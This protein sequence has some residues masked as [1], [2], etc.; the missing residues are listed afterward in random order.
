MIG[1]GDV[2]EVKSGPG[3]YKAE[4]ASLVAVAGR[5]PEKARDWV[6]RHNGARVCDTPEALLADP[7]IDIV[8]IATPPSTHK[9]YTLMAAKAG[10][11]VCVEKPMALDEGECRAMIAACAAA[12]VR[13]Y[14]A[15]YRRSMPRFI[16]V[17]EWIE[18]GAIGEV[19]TVR[20]VQ[21]QPAA[22][23]DKEPGR[24]PWRVRG[25]IA[26]GGKF[27]DMG[28]HELDFFDFLFGPIEEAHGLAANF[29]G[30]YDVEDTVNAVWR[31]K[32]GVQGSG[33]WCYVC[34]QEEDRTVITGSRGRIEFEF[35]SDKPLVLTNEHG[36]RTVSIPNP[37][38][39][40]QPFFQSITDELL[41]RGTCPG[42][43]EAAA[44]TSR[45]AGGLLS[46]YYAARA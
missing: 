28:V 34:G 36:V 30:L 27:V 20:V 12:G 8:Y 10:K 1:H 43:A 3:L 26:G 22:G 33:S 46:G 7:E 9:L 31:H 4:G 24:L 41:G 13:L 35:F 11:H 2:T 32:S 42:D 15:F 23:S 39:V 14:V 17:K 18:S 40:H 44:R 16:Q 38:H 19:R 29:G 5:T 6:A 25:E 21:H 37:A 45:V